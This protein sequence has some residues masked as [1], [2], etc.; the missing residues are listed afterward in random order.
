MTSILDSTIVLDPLQALSR[1]VKEAAGLL[2]RQEARFLVDYYYQTQEDRK[3]SG[4]QVRSVEDTG[5]PHTVLDWLTAN[6]NVLEK[7]I[8][9]ALAAY[10]DAHPVGRWAESIVGIGPIISAG[11]L[12]NIDVRLTPTVGHIWRFAGLDPTQ[13]WGGK[14]VAD[15]AVSA[16]RKDNSLGSRK[17]APTEKDAGFLAV[18]MAGLSPASILRLATTDKDG[19]KK[20]L[21]W[22]NLARALAVR[23]FNARLKTLC[24]KI[25]E[26]F[27]KV[28]NNSEDVYGHLYAERKEQEI[29]RNEAGDLAS[30]AE[31][32]LNRY[33]I[34]KT[35]DAYKWY[36]AGKLPPAHIHSRAKRWAVKL[37]LAHWH[38]VAYDIEYGTPP[39]K[40]YIL[41]QEGHTHY[42][43]P[44]NWNA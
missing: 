1:D 18:E 10:S 40:P 12:A 34:G 16:Y 19:D 29:A 30:Q 8:A 24:W 35:T 33:N 6:T 36:S 32:K 39:P 37:F 38:H 3:R 14:K 7:N 44:P 15:D 26:S 31:D 4:N 5:E 17:D 27:V 22:D 13:R 42:I 41:T 11:L 9:R 2:S 23:P 43:A 20:A 21:T 28:S 25:G